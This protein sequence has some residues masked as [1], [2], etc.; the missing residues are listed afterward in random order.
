MP[1][2]NTQQKEKMTEQ[3]KKKIKQRKEAELTSSLAKRLGVE[4]M[5]TDEEAI[6][7]LMNLENCKCELVITANNR[8]GSGPETAELGGRNQ[9]LK[10]AAQSA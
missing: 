6:Q 7:I 5:G 3:E 1:R 8:S 2:S 10:V 9:H 4:Y